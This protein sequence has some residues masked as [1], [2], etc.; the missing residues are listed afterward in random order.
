MRGKQTTQELLEGRESKSILKKDKRTPLSMMASE[1]GKGSGPCYH[2]LIRQE[3][4]ACLA[5]TFAMVIRCIIQV[6]GK[7]KAMAGLTRC[8]KVCP[9]KVLYAW[10]KGAT[11]ILFLNIDRRGSFLKFR[12][13]IGGRRWGRSSQ[14]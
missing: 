2:Q 7:T 8:N 3:V 5:A 11:R 13:E 9:S 10:S 12:W 6:C 4:Q 1:R 14:N